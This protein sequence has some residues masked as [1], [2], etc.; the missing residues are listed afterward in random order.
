MQ[1]N[2]NKQVCQEIFGSKNNVWQNY[3]GCCNR[4]VRKLYNMVGGTYKDNFNAWAV[5]I[6][7][8]DLSLNNM[9]TNDVRNTSEKKS[10]PMETESV[11]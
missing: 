4:D 9:K 6:M 1:K 5:K 10:I 8:N 2:F 3:I 11:T 7:L